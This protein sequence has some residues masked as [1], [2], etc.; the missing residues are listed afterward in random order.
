MYFYREKNQ[1]KI[2]EKHNEITA[3]II[4]KEG[5]IGGVSLFGNKRVMLDEIT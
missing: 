1:D 2:E 3:I 4:F 5:E